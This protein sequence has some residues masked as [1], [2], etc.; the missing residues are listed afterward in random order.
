MSRSLGSNLSS[1]A[2]FGP[3]AR[4][5]ITYL[6]G[7]VS[8]PHSTTVLVT[9]NRGRCCSSDRAAN[10]LLWTSSCCLLVLCL[11]I[12]VCSITDGR[13][14]SGTTDLSCCRFSFSVVVKVCKSFFAFCSSLFSSVFWKVCILFSSKH[15]LLGILN[16]RNF[17]M[18]SALLQLSRNFILRLLLSILYSAFWYCRYCFQQ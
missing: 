7:V 1:M 15:P 16:L 12:R 5:S 4:V 13:A 9:L 8:R 11:V 6:G 17:G 14:F 10:F 3:S 2:F 18:T